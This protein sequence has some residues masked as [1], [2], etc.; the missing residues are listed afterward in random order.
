M[1]NY[2]PIDL[3]TAFFKV[4]EKVMFNRLSHYMHT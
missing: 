1:T 4:L 2:K 3:L